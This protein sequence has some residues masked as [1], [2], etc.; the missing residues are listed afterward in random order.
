MPDGIKYS[1]TVQTN[2]LQKGN[3][4]IGIGNVGPTS[5]TN[6]YSAPIPASGK[7]IVSKV[8]VSGVPNFFAPS[9]EAEMI[10]LAKQEGATGANTASLASCL[11]WFASQTNYSVANLDYENI[12]T[13]GLILNLDA[14]FT[15]SYPT[16][17]TTWY[18]LSGNSYNGTLTNGPTFNSSNSGS[19][20]IDGVD[21]YISFPGNTFGYSPGTTGELSLEAWV[22]ATGPFSTY[23]PENLTALGG[24]IGQGI[25][26]GTIGWGLYIQRIS[27]GPYTYGFQVRNVGT[28]VAPSG[29]FTLNTWTHVI[30]T[31]TRNDFARVY[32]NGNLAASAS[33]TSLNGLTLTPNFNDAAIGRANSNN[34]FYIGGRVAVSRLYNRPLSAT[35][36]SQNYNTQ[37]GR[38]GL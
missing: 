38:F 12:V 3:V 8:A 36:V 16:T 21:D 37:K 14:G 34:P 1:T 22:Y 32:I 9:D 27:T 25:L 24:V 10:K 30:G 23:A 7:Y 17:G 11:A 13:D 18:D 15:T 2:S 5:T 26:N 31:F 20:V 35:E 19:I 33:S 28:V 6:F 29:S 4:A